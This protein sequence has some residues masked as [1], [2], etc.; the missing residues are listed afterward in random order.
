MTQLR[1]ARDEFNSTQKALRFLSIYAQFLEI[2]KLLR[3]V[4]ESSSLQIFRKCLDTDL[5]NWL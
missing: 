1:Y 4:E 2:Y 5:S 3:E